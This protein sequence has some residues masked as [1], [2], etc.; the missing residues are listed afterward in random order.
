MICLES[1]RCFRSKTLDH[2]LAI[3]HYCSSTLLLCPKDSSGE[4][5]FLLSNLVIWMGCSCGLGQGEAFTW[6]RVFLWD[7]E[8]G[9]RRSKFQT[10]AGGKAG[11]WEGRNWGCCTT[12][13]PMWR[14]WIWEMKHKKTR[15]ET[16]WSQL[17]PV[18]SHL[19]ETS[20]T[21]QP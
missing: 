15:R 16:P 8:L 14:K 17:P 10:V 6:I 20:N 12:L 2:H 21:S 11:I 5:F 19:L 9:I 4:C 18:F 7:L 3:S 13:S 1:R